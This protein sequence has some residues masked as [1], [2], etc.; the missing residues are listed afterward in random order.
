[1]W[2]EDDEDDLISYIDW[3]GRHPHCITPRPLDPKQQHLVGEQILDEENS[4]LFYT[5]SGFKPPKVDELFQPPLLGKDCDTSAVSIVANLS[6]QQTV[7]EYISHYDDPWYTMSVKDH[8]EQSHIDGDSTTVRTKP[9]KRKKL[10]EF[11]KER[12]WAD[13]LFGDY[14]GG[15]PVYPENVAKEL[16]KKALN[17]KH[18]LHGPKQVKGGIW[19]EK[20]VFT[21]YTAQGTE[22]NE[23]KQVELNKNIESALKIYRKE[24]LHSS[25]HHMSVAAISLVQK[26]SHSLVS[27]ARSRLGGEKGVTSLKEKLQSLAKDLYRYSNRQKKLVDTSLDVV[28]ALDHLRVSKLSYMLTNDLCDPNMKTF[29]EDHIFLYLFDKANAADVLSFHLQVGQHKMDSVDRRKMQKMLNLLLSHGVDVNTMD[30]RARLAAL[31][32]AASCDNSKM[33]LWLHSRKA[34]LN[35]LSRHGD[36]TPLM[37]ASMHCCVEAVATL[38]KCGARLDGVNSSGQT[39]L[40]ICGAFGQT[41][42]AQFLLRLGADKHIR[43]CRGQLAADLAF[44]K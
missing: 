24:N 36:M 4:R 3:H 39:A 23:Y 44:E 33:V 35:L 1:M 42:A 28:E 14:N 34:D 43:D 2:G 38:V 26:Q 19:K 37:L 22:L 25:S 7:I 40:H 32:S 31:H 27:E 17:D 9:Q 15:N 12:A 11:D 21:K 5:K 30:S 29:D 6:E 13:E 20:H 16:E 18:L 41:A 10:T 8:L